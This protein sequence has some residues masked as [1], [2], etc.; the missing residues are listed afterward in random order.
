MAKAVEAG[1]AYV[2]LGLKPN[3]KKGLESASKQMKAMGR[4]LAV[5][6]AAVGAA[7]A[8]VLGPLLKATSDFAKMGD[9]IHKMSARTGVAKSTLSELAFAIEQ[10]G[11]SIQDVEKA[12]FGLSRA[13]FDAGQ[14]SK[15]P[16]EA[17]KEI[18]LS[19]ADLEGMSPEEQF[20]RIAEAMAGVEDM[21][22]RGAVAQK[23]FGRSGRQMLPML[24]QGAAGINKLRQEARDLGRGMSGEDADAAAE[25]TDAMNR[26]ASVYKGIKTQ[27]GA[28]LAP[29]L[30]E[31]ATTFADMA[32]HVVKF[33]RENKSMIKIV[34][35]V[36]AGVVGLGGALTAAGFAMI[37]IGS[38]LSAIAGGLGF[39][40]SPI[41]AVIAGIAA[42]GFA[43]EHYFGFISKAIRFVIDRFEP[44]VAMWGDS[45]AAIVEALTQGDMEKAWE[46]VM[47]G[48]EGTFLDLTAGIGA[49]WDTA[50]N[51]LVDATSAM[52]KAIGGIIKQLGSWLQSMLK[53]YKDY[54]NSVYNNVTEMIGE[55]SG[56]RTIG[57]D[58]DAFGSA[59]DFVLEAGDSMM[60]FGDAM[61]DSAETWRQNNQRDVAERERDRQKRLNDI[62]E[63]AKREG[64]AARS[65]KKQRDEELAKL[66]GLNLDAGESA[67][68]AS[69][70]SVGTF[71]AAA[72]MVLG[73][74]GTVAEKQLKVQKENQKNTKE[75]AQNTKQN[76]MVFG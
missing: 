26:V 2:S 1:K 19:F 47:Q 56:V 55:L 44:L 10:S 59:G 4:S 58:V 52:A 23:L 15:M 66:E 9:E 8:A 28:A 64:D 21:S 41:G 37:G 16:N 57:G 36:A 25:Y 14:G 76:N 18:G 60:N 69:G 70:K 29:A 24:E 17:L 73:A 65:A 35:A 61:Q 68:Q 33:V 38:A 3:M 42:L 30:A 51:V 22:V 43:A 63:N 12:F 39:L 72:A 11:G 50:M 67:T 6:G 62:R 74:G 48:L 71:S 20:M 45:I 31:I 5:G 75:I 53:G 54:Y 7:G 27:I 46:L 49:Y 32:K 13:M 34:A 40:L